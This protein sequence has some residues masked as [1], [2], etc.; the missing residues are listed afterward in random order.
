MVNARS[1]TFTDDATEV[2]LP[3]DSNAAAPVRVGKNGPHS[4]ETA[5]LL[6]QFRKLQSTWYQELFQ[7]N[8]DRLQNS[9]N[10]VWQVCQDMHEWS[11][12][13]P[14]SLPLAFKEYFDLDLLYSYIYCLAPSC[15]IPAVST[16]VR[17]LIFE[18]SI[19]YMQ[20]IFPISGDP[21]NTAFYTYHDALRIYFVGCQFFSVLMENK[22]DL[23]NG[24]LPY[25]PT[26]AGSNLPPPL[27]GNTGVDSVERSINCIKHLKGALKTFGHRWEDSQALLSSIETQAEP[28]LAILHQRKHHIEEVSRNS[29][30]PPNYISQPVYDQMGT[31]VGEEWTNVGGPAHGQ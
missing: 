20:K 1:F 31:Y 5:S 27:P 19:T 13:F 8:R 4:M 10:Y 22:D 12:S 9:T 24:I 25:P 30:S 29:H 2:S 28:L 21:I 16:Y 23:L 17:V 15:R 7:S 14:D 11:E 18:Y 3:F 6:F 26:T